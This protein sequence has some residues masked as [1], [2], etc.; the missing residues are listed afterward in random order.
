MDRDDIRRS[1]AQVPLQKAFA[2][3]A[4]TVE[5]VTEKLF[6]LAD[7][8]L[9]ESGPGAGEAQLISLKLVFDDP[10]EGEVEVEDDDEDED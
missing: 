6:V 9:R 10:D 2:S 7:E 3:E 8:I 1:L 4:V 5:A